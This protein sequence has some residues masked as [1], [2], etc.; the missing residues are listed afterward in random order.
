MRWEIVLPLSLLG[1][2]AITLL[3]FLCYADGLFEPIKDIVEVVST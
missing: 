1:L 3:T 2:I